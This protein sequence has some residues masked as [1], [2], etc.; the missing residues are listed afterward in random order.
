MEDR[1]YEELQGDVKGLQ[2]RLKK[3]EEWQR[4]LP[5][6]VFIVL[7]FT[8]NSGMIGVIIGRAIEHH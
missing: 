2:K 6:R 1:H 7:A 8:F 3:V 5:F 4:D